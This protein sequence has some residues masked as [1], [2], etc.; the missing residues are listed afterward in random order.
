MAPPQP[1]ESARKQAKND[2]RQ[3]IIDATAALLHQFTVEAVSVNAIAERAQ[4]SPATVYNLF[5]TRTRIFLDLF[6]Q[7]QEKFRQQAMLLKS[8]NAINYLMDLVGLAAKW[9]RDDPHYFR[10]A[11]GV[12]LGINDDSVRFAYEKPRIN[13]WRAAADRAI[14]EEILRSTTDSGA[15]AVLLARL[16]NGVWVEWVADH[17][18]IDRAEQELRYGMSVALLAHAAPKAKARLEKLLTETERDL[19]L[20]RRLS[21]EAAR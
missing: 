1:R 2:R 5:G 14:S 11:L 19:T 9:Y 16:F 21:M 12:I 8:P 20:V 15:L 3:R 7:E 10:S 4:T 13:V 17:I 18:S 6:N